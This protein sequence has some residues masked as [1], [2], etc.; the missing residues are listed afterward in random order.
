MV[1]ENSGTGAGAGQL[2]IQSPTAQQ[3]QYALAAVNRDYPVTL[4]SIKVKG[5]YDG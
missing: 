4:D 5:G 2:L 3:S 1:L